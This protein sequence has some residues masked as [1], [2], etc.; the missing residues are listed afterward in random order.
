MY[1]CI[2]KEMDKQ[3]VHE[4]FVHQFK[5]YLFNV[6]HD[7]NK[8]SFRAIDETFQVMWENNYYEKMGEMEEAHNQPPPDKCLIDESSDEEDDSHME[9]LRDRLLKEQVKNDKL[10]IENDRLKEENKSLLE[11]KN[12]EEEN[13][14]FFWVEHDPYVNENNPL[15]QFICLC[16]EVPDIK[17]KGVTLAPT[18]FEDIFYYYKCW[19]KQS[20]YPVPDK[21]KTKMDLLRWQRDSKYSL[22]IGKKIHEKCK[23][24][25][26]VNPRFNLWYEHEWENPNETECD[27]GEI[28]GF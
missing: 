9:W 3:K 14:K 16:N 23:N 22:E 7:F 12:Q 5:F 2:E 15:K 17:E 4:E 20:A 27:A 19:C 6:G 1:I 24:G 11:F 13:R 18:E 10:G 26:N 25:T 21:K 28:H 8:A